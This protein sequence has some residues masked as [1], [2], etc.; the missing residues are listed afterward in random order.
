MDKRTSEQDLKPG[1]TSVASDPSFINDAE[2]G[3]EGWPTECFGKRTTV[4]DVRETYNAFRKAA[5]DLDDGEQNDK[6]K[7]RMVAKNAFEASKIEPDTALAD[8]NTPKLTP[9]T[10]TAPV[11]VSSAKAG[12]SSRK[13]ATGS[14]RKRRG[15][16]RKRRGP[17]ESSEAEMTSGV[18]TTSG[19]ELE[20][21]TSTTA[22]RPNLRPRKPSV[23]LASE[24]SDRDS[25][26]VAR[27]KEYEID[28]DE[29][30][31]LAKERKKK[32]KQKAK[33]AK[34]DAR[35]AGRARLRREMELE[36]LGR[37]VM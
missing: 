18:E 17:V 34:M 24:N 6:G 12:S 31:D 25:D 35:R 13:P 27:A 15:S 4:Q 2:A 9:C 14:K 20:I 11:R 3:V 30:Y 28:S 16:Q 5:G 26:V 7:A 19:S 37:N 22:K 21:D 10:P 1:T 36:E 8:I 23:T 32:A 29:V 33:D